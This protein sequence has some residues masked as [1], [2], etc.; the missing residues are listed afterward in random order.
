MSGISI[1]LYLFVGSVLLFGGA[2]FLIRGGASFALR[3]GVPILVIA[4]TI[5]GY[6]TG[7]PELVVS[8]QIVWH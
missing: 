7:T 3:M 2:E 5:M 8:V 6:G 4:L 1:G